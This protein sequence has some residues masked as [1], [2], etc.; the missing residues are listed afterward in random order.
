MAD[1]PSEKNSS[2]SEPAPQQPAEPGDEPHSGG[3][4]RSTQ[5]FLGQRL[6]VAF[7]ETGPKPAYLGD[8]AI[9]AEFEHQLLRLEGRIEVHEKGVDAV[10][11]ALDDID[12]L[13]E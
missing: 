1:D 10:R 3:L 12:P 8:P 13:E 5:D 4:D 6:R 11:K 2:A 9:P 7:N